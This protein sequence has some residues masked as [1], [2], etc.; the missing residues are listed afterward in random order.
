MSK[1]L[2]DKG[3][4]IRKTV[5]GAKHVDR[6]LREADDFTAPLQEFLTTYCW[7][8]LW[9]RPGL[10]IKQRI[11]INLAVLAAVN[12]Q[13]EVKGYVKAALRNGCTKVEIRETLLQVA[14]YCGMPAGVEA[15]KLAREAFQEIEMEK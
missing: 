10:E 14:V 1:E 11:L 5:L 6:Q 9:N 7:G 13:P 2:Y 12:R 3:I 8:W 15:F 4:A